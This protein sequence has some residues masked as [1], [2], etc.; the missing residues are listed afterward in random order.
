MNELA[1]LGC[2]VAQ[3]FHLSRPLPSDEF[4]EWIA[5]RDDVATVARDVA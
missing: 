1:E 2:N 4:A 3:G 5:D